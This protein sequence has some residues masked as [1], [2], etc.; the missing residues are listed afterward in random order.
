[1]EEYYQRRPG[2][3]SGTP[4][5]AENE[6]PE[7]GKTVLSEYDQYRQSLVNDDDDEGWNSEYRRYLK[8]RPANVKKDTDIIQ[9]WQVCPFQSEISCRY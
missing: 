2:R 1:M 3:S 9:W 5:T 7:N 4:S 8:D 6:E